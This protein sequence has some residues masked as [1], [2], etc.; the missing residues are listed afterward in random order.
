MSFDQKMAAKARNRRNQKKNEKAFIRW[1]HGNG[2][3]NFRLLFNPV[4]QT[5]LGKLLTNISTYVNH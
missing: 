5:P 1:N 4:F 2:R 3:A